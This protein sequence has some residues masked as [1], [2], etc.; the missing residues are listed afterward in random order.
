MLHTTKLLIHSLR[1]NTNNHRFILVFRDE[2]DG[3]RSQRIN[4]NLQIAIWS[5]GQWG[6]RMDQSIP[7]HHRSSEM[8]QGLALTCGYQLTTGPSYLTFVLLTK[9]LN[10][11]SR[12]LSNRNI[13][14]LQRKMCRVENLPKKVRVGKETTENK[15][16]WL[17]EIWVGVAEVGV[18]VSER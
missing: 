3:K 13:L 8:P 6:R 12:V 16:P 18:R 1:A 4:S 14:W 17:I 15:R 5:L 9:E 7:L 2:E 10:G 11:I